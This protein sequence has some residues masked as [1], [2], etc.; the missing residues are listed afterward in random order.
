MARNESKILIIGGTGYIGSYM[1][2]ASIKLGHPTYVYSRPNSSKKESLNEFESMGALIVK[3][4]LQDHEKLVSVIREVDVVISA[5]AYPQ[6]LDQLNIIEA[7][8]V[9]GGIK[10]FLPSDF[11]CE[12]DRI[13]VLPPFQAFLDKKKKIRRAIEQANI[14][15]TFVS[16]NCFGAY[17]INYLLHPHE[18]KE[19]I[20]V[21]G[22]GQAK[23]VLNFEEDIGIYTI[24]VATDP[25]ACNRVVLYRPPTNIISQLELISLWEKKTGRTF[26]KIHVPE[27]KI[28]T[29]SKTLPDPNNI[30]VSILHSVFIKGVTMNFD[31]GEN[32]IEASLLYPDI[33]FTT[34][35]DLLD[36]FLR[37]PPKPAS[38]AFE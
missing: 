19:E 30:P 16:A 26:K 25:R 13:S 35:D 8:K 31:L 36:V 2:K 29:L 15:Y 32:D 18:L 5:V 14:P 21:Y 17:F 34:V 11:G 10:R 28:V 33:K 1:V 23:A 38:A 20:T 22:S 3:G 7:I 24:K 4:E 9:A 37:N 12:E 27:E 6:V